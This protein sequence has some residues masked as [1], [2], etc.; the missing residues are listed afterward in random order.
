M[1]KKQP[2]TQRSTPRSHHGL[3]RF[4]K[5]AAQWLG[6]HIHTWLP[7]VT[8]CAVALYIGTICSYD[9][10]LQVSIDGVAYG[11]VESRDTISDA[12]LI[13]EEQ[14]SADSGSPYRL[15]CKV[16]YTFTHARNPVYLTEADFV[17]ILQTHASD[18]FCDAYMLYVDDVQAAAYENREELQALI[19]SI[20]DELLASGGGEYCRVE[21]SNRLRIE[22]QLCPRHMLYSLEAIN[23]LLNPLA[24][25]SALHT[26]D[27]LPSLRVNAFTSVSPILHED[28]VMLEQGIDYSVTRVTELPVDPADLTLEYTLVRTETQEEVIYYNVQNIDDYDNFI[29]T[30]TVVQEGS[31]GLRSVT[32][33]IRYD[34]NGNEVSRTVTE[35]RI[36]TEAQ[37]KIVMVGAVEIPDPVPTGTFIWPCETPKGISSPYGGR[38]LY[39]SYDFHL[40]I[41]LPGDEGSPIYA[42]DGGEIIWAGY[43]PSYGYSIRIQ[44][45]DN[46]ITLYAHLS[47]MLVSVGDRVYQGQQIGEMG[48]TGAAYGTHLHFEVRIGSLTKNP[49]NYLPKREG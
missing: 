31:N 28:T 11:L 23:E 29:G 5:A 42:S 6:V 41:D 49:M 14:L 9:I 36:I 26:A 47:E 18:D 43:T 22:K 1:L 33:D 8:A 10:V 48:H 38:D 17:E 30:D 37:D 4:I 3:P 20:E 13:V 39:G 25:H 15:D 44:H 19:D 16:S 45:N 7:L 46:Y 12:A 32:Y 34:A 35:T 40:G 24:D 21:I 2:D 27:Q